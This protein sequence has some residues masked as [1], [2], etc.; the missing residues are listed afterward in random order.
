VPFPKGSQGQH[1][2]PILLKFNV[3]KTF[4]HNHAIDWYS[5]LKNALLCHNGSISPFTHMAHHSPVILVI[6][7]RYF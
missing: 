6:V 2:A 7:E 4:Q 1:A 3:A 5:C